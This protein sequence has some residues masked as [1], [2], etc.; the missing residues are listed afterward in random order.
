MRRFSDRRIWPLLLLAAGMTWWLGA[1][2]D[3]FEEPVSADPFAHGAIEGFCRDLDKQG[4][5]PV[6]GARVFSSPPS[7]STSTDASG[8]FFLADVPPGSYR[9]F[10]YSSDGRSAS[11]DT[12]VLPGSTSTVMIDF[13]F[14]TQP[15][16]MQ[17]FYIADPV[18]SGTGYTYVTN[19]YGLAPSR[20]QPEL[21]WNITAVRLNPA[22]RNE[23]LFASTAEE[24]HGELY[25]YDTYTRTPRRVTVNSV[26]EAGMD[27][28]PD[29]TRIVYAADEDGDGNRE[30]IVVGR[31]GV[32]GRIVLVDDYE[33]SSGA[34]YDSAWPCWAP[35]GI[36][37][38]FCLRRTDPGA[39]VYEQDFELAIAPLNGDPLYVLTSDTVDDIHPYW[40][41]N[42]L[43]IVYAKKYNSHYQ[44][45]TRTRDASSTERRLT[46]N[47]YDHLHPTFSN[48]GRHLCWLA[49]DDPCGTN[50][51]HNFEVF[52][53][54]YQ[55]G[56]LLNVTQIT[57][58]SGV[59]HSWPQFRP[60]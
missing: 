41:P 32:S 6:V 37:I 34:T 13:G 28:S 36:S 39:P 15:N 20:F 4:T 27:I 48:D 57:T 42:S 29:G 24:S 2:A 8:R 26:E 5:P 1:C 46:L 54:E 25:L 55:G 44:L 14:G 53:A 9:V 18:V 12:V 17:I 52:R 16:T 30:L 38:V 35:D 33:P 19:L 3:T 56:Y 45:Y 60:R 21:G 22:D 11:T 31:D 59:T 7:A 40:H 23:I 10:A 49:D 58:T 43:T 47:L 50:S 51:D